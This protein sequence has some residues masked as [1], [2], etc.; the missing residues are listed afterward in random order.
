LYQELSRIAVKLNHKL[1]DFLFPLFV[2]MIGS[3]SGPPLF[4]AMSLL[5]PDM[6]RARLRSA[7][8]AAGGVSKKQIKIWEKDF[9][10]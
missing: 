10:H 8:E 5:G 2:A 9:R 7:L 1:K 3:A 6:V 4:D